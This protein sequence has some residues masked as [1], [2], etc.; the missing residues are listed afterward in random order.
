MQDTMHT[1]HPGQQPGQGSD[2]FQAQRPYPPVQVEGP[3][4]AYARMLG[5]DLAGGLS[6]MTSVSQYTYQNWALFERCPEVARAMGQIARVEMHH[7]RLLGQTIVLLGGDPRYWQ[8]SGAGRPVW[9]S[10]ATVCYTDSIQKMMLENIA[11]EQS[12][13]DEY[14]KQKLLV[15]DPNIV[16]LLE[17]ILEDEYLHISLFRRFLEQAQR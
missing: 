9:W 14:T 3:N 6:E 5:A 8:L 15:R 13:I 4:A 17:R 10:G 12:A 11:L 1:M 2:P 16:A 7:M